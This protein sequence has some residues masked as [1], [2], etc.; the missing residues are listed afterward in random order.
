MPVSNPGANSELL[1]F[2]AGPTKVDALVGSNVTLAVSFSGAP[3]PALTW[4]MKDLPVVTWTINSASLPDIANN[5]SMV[6]SLEKDGSLTFQDVSLA[7]SSDYRVRMTKSGLGTS[8]ITFTLKV[9]GA[10]PME[11]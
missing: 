11:I 7:C 3:D 8:S 10:Y 9:F 5:K 6:L 2:P 1:V 4:F